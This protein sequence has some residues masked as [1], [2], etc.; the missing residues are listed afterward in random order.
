VIK[1]RRMRWVGHVGC[2]GREE[3]Y[4]GFWWENLWEIEHLGDPSLDKKYY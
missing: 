1:Y 2:M 3:A 4:T